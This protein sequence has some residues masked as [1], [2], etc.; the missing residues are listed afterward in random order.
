MDKQFLAIPQCQ[1]RALDRDHFA[2]KAQSM[3]GGVVLK[4]LARRELID[5]GPP[6]VL[7]KIQMPDHTRDGAVRNIV[8]VFFQQNLFDAHHVPL[9][10]V[11]VLPDKRF[12]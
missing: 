7:S 11:E 10:T 8:A 3:G 6:V 9:A 5:A 4:L 1:G 12:N 2:A